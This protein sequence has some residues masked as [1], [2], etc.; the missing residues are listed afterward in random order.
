MDD[1]QKQIERHIKSVEKQV[2]K[3][4]L[5]QARRKAGTK[6]SAKKPRKKDWIPDAWDEWDDLEYPVV[7]KVMP[8]GSEDRR[9]KVAKL[10]TDSGGRSER[11]ADPG[12]VDSP[13]GSDSREHGLVVEV[14]SGKCRVN[15]KGESMLC[16]LR[17]NLRKTESEYANAVSVGDRVIISQEGQNT[18]V[19]ETVLPRKNILARPH[20]TDKSLQQIIVTNVDRL[21][22]VASWREPNLWPELI[23]RYLITAQRNQ[24]DP[25]ICINKVDL[26]EDE[27]ELQTVTEVYRDL[28]Y[29]LLLTSMVSGQGID[30]LESLLKDGTTVLAG[31]S[32]VGKSSLL[33]AVQPDLNLRT[34]NVSQRGLFTGQGRHTTTQSSLWHLSNGGIVIDTPGIRKF[35]LAD[36]RRG[37]LAQAYPEMVPLLGNCR[38]ANCSHSNEPECAVRS[39]VDSGTISSLRFKNYTQILDCLQE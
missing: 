31:L 20:S 29:P 36:M 32:G 26:V 23:D 11:V 30:E 19:V 4:K 14:S 35:G 28:G 5:R 16:H 12:G 7:E 1:K 3:Q 39:A 37:Q 22:I 9:R 24:I 8:R 27:A 6:E 21:L 17:G 33:V 2:A 25:V 34:A 18:G 13:P 15:L 38:F 10:A